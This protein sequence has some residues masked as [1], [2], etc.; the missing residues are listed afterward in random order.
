MFCFVC[1]IVYSQPSDAAVMVFIHGGGY[2]MGAGSSTE[3][4]D[5]HPFSALGNVVVVTINYR[6]H[7]LGFLSTGM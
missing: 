7:V 4:F 6:L 2:Y 1:F 3:V 5:F